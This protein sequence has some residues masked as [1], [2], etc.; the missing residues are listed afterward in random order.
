MTSLLAATLG[1]SGG[2]V[3]GVAWNLEVLVWCCCARLPTR[4][5][6]LH[7]VFGDCSYVRCRLSPRD[8]AIIRELNENIFALSFLETGGI[9]RSESCEKVGYSILSRG[10][11]SPALHRLHLVIFDFRPPGVTESGEAA[12]RDTAPESCHRRLFVDF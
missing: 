4:S 3:A 5:R 1:H 8:R 12:P 6:L 7:E 10:L 11:A 9:G 2:V